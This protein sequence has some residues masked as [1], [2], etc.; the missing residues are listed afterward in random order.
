MPNLFIDIETVPSQRTDI[1]EFIATTIKHPKQMKKADTIAKWEVEEKPNAI[2]KEWLKTS[3]DGGFG[4]IISFACAIDDSNIVSEVRKLEEPESVLLNKL[5]KMFY[6]VRCIVGHN[7]LN[8]DLRFAH[9]RFLVSNIKSNLYFYFGSRNDSDIVF[10]T[11]LEWS[12]RYNKSDYCSLEKMCRIFNIDI[13]TG[14][15]SQVW[16]W[17][18]SGQYDKIVEHNKTDLKA[19]RELFYKMNPNQ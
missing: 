9:Q 2:E 3:L 13:P 16:E 12:G 19:T 18:S 17:A 8:F 15:G 14:K 10:D 1:K 6:G 7:V 11:M 4:E 5:N